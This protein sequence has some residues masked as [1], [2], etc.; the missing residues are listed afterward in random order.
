M[1]FRVGDVYQDRYVS[2]YLGDERVQHRKHPIMAPGE[3]EQ[4]VLKRADL[5]ARPGISRV[6]VAI[7]EE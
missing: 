1:R 6:T 5:L 7:E 3:M 4:V 2:V